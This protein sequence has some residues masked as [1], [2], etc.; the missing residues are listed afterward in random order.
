MGIPLIFWVF[1]QFLVRF[2]VFFPLAL[3]NLQ[4]LPKL[5]REFHFLDF[6]YRNVIIFLL[7]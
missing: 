3:A 1:Y 5:P 6:T 7:P 4:G 2:F